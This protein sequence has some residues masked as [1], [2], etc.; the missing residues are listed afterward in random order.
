[1]TLRKQLFLLISLIFLLV[2]SGVLVLAV[3]S[4]ADYLEQQLGSQ[5]Q[6][7][8]TSLA[9]SLQP[10]VEKGDNG[11]IEAQ[12]SSVFDRGYFQHIVLLSTTSEPLVVKELPR[13]IEDAPLWFTKL[14]SLKTPG[15][16]AFV[17]SGWRQYGKVLVMNQPTFAYQHLWNFTL[18]I[19][20]VL[21]LAYLLSITITQM[22]LK[23]ILRPLTQIEDTAIAIQERR[24]EQID[25]LPKTRELYRVVTAMNQM[26]SWISEVL[27][28]EAAKAAVLWREAYVDTLT[29]VDNRRSFNLRLNQILDNESC[30]NGGSMV[31]IEV[32]GLN[33]F[34]SIDQESLQLDAAILTALAQALMDIVGERALII[35]RIRSNSF[36]FVLEKTTGD[37]LAT[38]CQ[39][40]QHKMVNELA[41]CGAD[42]PISFCMGGAWFHDGDAFSQILGRVDLCLETARQ[43]AL[44]SYYIQPNQEHFGSLG[45]LGWKTLI[46]NALKLNHWVMMAQPVVRLADQSVI[47]W[48]IF[49]RLI[50]IDGTLVP[51]SRFMPMAARHNL[52][53]D[54][55]RAFLTM[56]LDMLSSPNNV[57]QD[58]AINIAA[59]SLDEEEFLS[60]LDKLL[61]TA[62]S[63]AA[64]ISLEISEFGCL[65]NLEA[66]MRF[67]RMLRERGV[68]LGIDHF[69]VDPRSLQILRQ[70]QPDYVKLDGGLINGFGE[71]AGS[72]SM[73]QSII[74][75]ARS[76]N[77]LVIAHCVENSEQVPLLM[78]NNIEAGQ[79]YFFGAPKQI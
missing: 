34:S 43:S 15:G 54:V 22:F 32:N 79:G 19:S 50:N 57:R 3:T 60:W 49:S 52:V 29:G 20:A 47:H 53:K 28:A 61:L 45:S 41:L 31:I 30:F 59:Q 40:I 12:V 35:G 27:N 11:L 70:I 51:A 77:V 8:A 78:A 36:A 39:S 38:L 23:R 56:A 1:M 65:R 72:D 18:K 64:N 10:M 37:E 58:V 7:T 6:E 71:G 48:E 55:D 42:A 21:V 62:G 44:N 66:S 2:Y 74:Q 25:K 9:Q 68:K 63:M 14:V 17:T 16:E 69:G 75:I 13:K 33:E 26:S 46:H 67:R 73:L 24:F 76:L 4:T 5:A